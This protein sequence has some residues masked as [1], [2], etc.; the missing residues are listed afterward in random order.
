MR[1]RWVICS[2]FLFVLFSRARRIDSQTS[3]VVPYSLRVSVDEVILTFH[4]NDAHGLSI[5]D[6]KID[7]LRLFDNGKPPRRILAFQ[8]LQDFPIRA[9]I[10]MDTS[11]SMWEDLPVNRAISLKYA[12]SL[13]RQQTDQAF[14]M[15]FGSVSRILQPWSSDPVALAAGI[16]KVIA[17]KDSRTGVT[18]AIF[19]TIYGACRY[20]FG[21]IDHA[22]SGNFILLFSDGEDNGSYLPLKEAVDMCQHTNTAIY[23]FRAGMESSGF[24]S[25][26]E[27]ASETGGRVFRASASE[28][29][30]YD[31]LRTIEADLRN[32]YRLIYKP[33]ELMHDGAFHRIELKAA[34]RVDSITIRSGYYAPSRLADSQP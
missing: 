12:R 10:V 6:L 34:E 8:L 17:G 18:T 4:A 24:K 11:A 20:Q 13:L 9:G 26:T 23:A 3:P 16:G 5:N 7:E 1:E 28:A 22:A 15:N 30:I 14:V 19:D 33:S 27:L 25:L 29:E 32:Q 2:L 21:K 31:D